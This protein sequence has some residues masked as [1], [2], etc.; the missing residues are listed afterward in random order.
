LFRYIFAIVILFALAGCSSA[1]KVEDTVPSVVI[2]SKYVLV[3]AATNT[4][5]KFPRSIGEQAGSAGRDIREFNDLLDTTFRQAL[6]GKLGVSGTR[7][8]LINY[9]VGGF[10]YWSHENARNRLSTSITVSGA[11]TTVDP[12]PN[13]AITI[14]PIEVS[15]NIPGS[16]SG[17][18]EASVFE[19]S[20]GARLW[21]AD[22]TESR[23]ASPSAHQEV[24]VALARHIFERLSTL[25]F[26]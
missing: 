4:L 1:P 11:K 17:K 7:A 10:S 5:G 12:G 6:L 2:H 13:I 16:F 26:I 20:S 9:T 14:E 25:G 24:G 3:V 21:H 19:V 15:M 8:Q 18:F 22:F 23:Y